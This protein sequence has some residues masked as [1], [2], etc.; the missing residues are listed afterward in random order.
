MGNPGGV[1][2]GLLTEWRELLSMSKHILNVFRKFILSAAFK[3]LPL[4]SASLVEPDPVKSPLHPERDEWLFE[5][6]RTVSAYMSDYAGEMNRLAGALGGLHS[7][8]SKISVE[9]PLAVAAELTPVF[10]AVWSDDDLF[11]G[12]P[13]ASV[14]AHVA[15]A[16]AHADFLFEDNKPVIEGYVPFHENARAA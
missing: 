5:K 16:T 9:A 15:T 1:I 13:L 11:E 12:E 3:A 8:L 10:G 7:V 2:N 6:P 4:R 14:E